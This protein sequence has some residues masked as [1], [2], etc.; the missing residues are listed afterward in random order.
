[1]DDLSS[2]QASSVIGAAVEAFEGVE[3][4]T[5][6]G[7]DILGRRRLV[8]SSACKEAAHVVKATV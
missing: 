7:L 1:V 8:P 2:Y 4:A 5:L 6:E 3:Q